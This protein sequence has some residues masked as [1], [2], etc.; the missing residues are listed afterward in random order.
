MLSPETFV[1]FL[2]GP[3][4]LLSRVRPRSDSFAGPHPPPYANV[5]LRGGHDRLVN[6]PIPFESSRS[7]ASCVDRVEYRAVDL[8]CAEVEGGREVSGERETEGAVE[9][10]D[11][12]WGVGGSPSPAGNNL[13]R[14]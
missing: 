5:V 12:G 9:D 3:D 11:A 10:I 7:N 14:I 8:P 13:V 4:T 2:L 6:L 1:G